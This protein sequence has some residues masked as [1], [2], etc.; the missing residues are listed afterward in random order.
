MR[1]DEGKEVRLA[2]DP[3]DLHK[4]FT[5]IGLGVAGWM[6]E[7]DEHL[8]RAQPALPHVILHDGVAA[9]EAVL[10]PQPFQDPLRRVPLLYGP[11]LIFFQDPVDHT[12]ERVEH[13]RGRRPGPPIS[14]RDRERQHLANRVPVQPEQ[15]RRLTDAHP[16]DMA[17]ASNTAVELHSVHTPG[18]PSEFLIS[19]LKEG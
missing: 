4:R 2:L 12:R 18:L 5:E 15:P 19:S 9:R 8:P 17:G 3:P 7:R 14:G 6:H 10:V 16:V 11:C 1:Q 13:G